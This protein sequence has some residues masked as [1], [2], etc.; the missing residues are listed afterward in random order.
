MAR[1]GAEIMGELTRE[2]DRE[3]LTSPWAGAD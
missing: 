3:L 2:V 1:G